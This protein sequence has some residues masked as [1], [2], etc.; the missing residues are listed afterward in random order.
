MKMPEMKKISRVGLVLFLL[1]CL[2]T[3]AAAAEDL[4]GNG[5]IRLTL[6][7]ALDR[8]Q[9]NSL[10]IEGAALALERAEFEEYRQE[11]T[12]RDIDPARDYII[13]N[14]NY[15]AAV[16]KEVLVKQ[17]EVART[18]RE[19][20]Y[21][22]QSKAVKMEAENA[23]YGLLKAQNDLANSRKALERAKEQMRL[24]QVSYDNGM[25]SRGDLKGAQAALASRQA[26]VSASEASWEKA[27]MNL[28]AATGMPLNSLLVAAD[29]VAFQDFEVDLQEVLTEVLEND[30][31][32]L[33]ARGAL[34]VATLKFEIADRYYTPNTYVYREDNFTRREAELNL[35][36]ARQDL[37]Q[38][39]RGAWYD[40]SSARAAYQV[41]A[42]SL[43]FAE[44][45]YR[46]ARVRYGEGMATRMEVEEAE[47]ALR[48]QEQ[49]VAAMLYQ[50]NLA[51]ARFRYG[52][53]VS[54]G[55]GF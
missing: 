11:R 17:K 39:V 41:L 10:G 45:N 43:P 48:E 24:S 12:S 36:Q 5:E 54:G 38:S 35:R 27:R 49:E 46:V 14:S 20:A 52:L 28:A 30:L 33:S 1:V 25:I 32:I 9:K 37:E 34:E 51:R 21:E 2:I 4:S 47:G 13:Y 22:V 8:A 29:K 55:A 50:Y 18:V 16:T 15:N 42:A 31:S 7:E 53:F 23:Y 44:E 3:P 19:A 6:E 40:L 26:A